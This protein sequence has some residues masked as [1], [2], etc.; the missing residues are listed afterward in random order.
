MKF[1]TLIK[2]FTTT[3]NFQGTSLLL[4]KV[5]GVQWNQGFKDMKGHMLWLQLTSDKKYWSR[6]TAKT[7]T[8]NSFHVSKLQD[9]L[10]GGL[11]FQDI[12]GWPKQNTGIVDFSELCSDQQLSLFTLL[13]RASFPYYNNTKIIKFGWELCIL[14]VISYGLSFSGFARFPDLM[15]LVLL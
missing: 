12:P 4:S 14:W 1:D 9:Y 8:Y 15:I 13:D 2:L 10:E 5:V 3:S 11:L 7:I 6:K